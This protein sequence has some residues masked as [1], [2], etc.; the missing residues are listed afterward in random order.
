M[1][2]GVELPLPR[3]RATGLKKAAFLVVGW[4]TKSDALPLNQSIQEKGRAEPR[5]CSLPHFK[6]HDLTCKQTATILSFLYSFTQP[7]P[8]FI[9]SVSF[10]GP[11]NH[12]INLDIAGS[13][14]G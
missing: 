7:F 13:G 4:L 6:S 9:S 11:T 2:G 5:I 14:R 12:T 1:K 8:F 10:R 3:E